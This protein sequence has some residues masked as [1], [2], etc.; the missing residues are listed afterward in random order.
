MIRPSPCAGQTGAWLIPGSEV[1]L[2]GRKRDNLLRLGCIPE[3]VRDQFLAGQPGQKSQSH[4]QDRRRGVHQRPTSARLPFLTLA[5]ATNLEPNPKLAFRIDRHR[6]ETTLH[7]AQERHG[8]ARINEVA[9][10]RATL[11]PAALNPPRRQQ[12]QGR[13]SSAAGQPGPLDSLQQLSESSECRARPFWF[14][15][16][17]ELSA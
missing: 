12:N 3:V 9:S 7:T 1:W 13:V 6:T 2:E 17:R 10:H 14:P 11:K 16:Q 4:G 15:P 5:Q 8:R